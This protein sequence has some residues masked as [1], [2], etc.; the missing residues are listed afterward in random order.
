MQAMHPELLYRLSTHG[1]RHAPSKGHHPDPPWSYVAPLLMCMP[2]YDCMHA[3]GTC[4][5]AGLLGSISDAQLA[6]LSQRWTCDI[7]LVTASK[8]LLCTASSCKPS[9]SEECCSMLTQC[10]DTAVQA[11][12][13][14]HS[15]A[16]LAS[17]AGSVSIGI[18]G[19][20]ALRP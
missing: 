1:L 11:Y 13:G 9:E 14:G 16:A 6:Y 17:L 8:Q 12:N 15:L 7:E 2:S 3:A 18:P 20:C 5:A 10:K 19:T 4:L